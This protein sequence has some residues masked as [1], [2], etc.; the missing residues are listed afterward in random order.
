MS[1]C[2]ARYLLYLVILPILF[3]LAFFNLA[4]LSFHRLGLSAE[5]AVALFL[6]A[7]LG[8]LVNVPIARRRVVIAPARRFLWGWLYIYYQPPVVAE[9][10][11]A[12]NVGGAVVPTLVALS[13]LPRVPFLPTLA[14][15]AVV[16]AATHLLARPVPG[17]GIVLPALAPPL[18]SA[19]AALTFA[20]PGSGAVAYVAGT[21]GTL[22]GAD[23]LHLRHLHRLGGTVV[24]IGGAG[25]FDGIFLVGVVAVLLT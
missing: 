25:V 15:F 16:T 13:L 5:A 11:L 21:L 12:V 19:L 14:A 20:G 10:V 6:A 2:L 22:A 8:S 24:S 7:L 23:L 17:R 1:G 3:A 18:I 9:T 4:T